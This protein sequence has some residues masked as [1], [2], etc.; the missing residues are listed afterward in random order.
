MPDLQPYL[1][2]RWKSAAM[3]NH[4][5]DPPPSN[6]SPCWLIQ[7]CTTASPSPT[8]PHHGAVEYPSLSPWGTALRRCGATPSISENG[9]RGSCVCNAEV[10]AAMCR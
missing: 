9:V 7:P 10:G 6:P 8:L 4:W 3:A 1:P 2:G 5:T